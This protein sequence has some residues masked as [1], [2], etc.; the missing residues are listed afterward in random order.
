MRFPRQPAGRE[1]DSDTSDENVP[2]P[3][4]K[5][6]QIVSGRRHHR[7][8]ILDNRLM[9]RDGNLEESLKQRLI[10][11]PAARRSRQL[12]GIVKVSNARIAHPNDCFVLGFQHHHGSQ[13]PAAVMA[14]WLSSTA[15]E[16][17]ACGWCSSKL[18]GRKQKDLFPSLVP[19]L[20]C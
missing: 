3:V 9:R 16:S 6:A 13:L 14:R 11:G 2:P 17:S 5:S 12:V 4:L 19:L 20:P 15:E 1:E 8:Y 10:K 18:L 7:L